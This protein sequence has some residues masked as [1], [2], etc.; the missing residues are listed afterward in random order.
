MQMHFEAAASITFWHAQHLML[1]HKH[2][3]IRSQCTHSQSVATITNTHSHTLTHKHVRIIM[4]KYCNT[5][6]ER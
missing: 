5:V 3:V 6:I 4:R 1:L 2:S